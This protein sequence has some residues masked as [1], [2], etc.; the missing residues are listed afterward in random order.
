M[1]AEPLTGA[2][3]GVRAFKLGAS[4]C[5][6]GWYARAPGECYVPHPVCDLL[7]PEVVGLPGPISTLCVST[8]LYDETHDDAV[9]V[10]FKD[11][12]AWADIE[13]PMLAFSDHWG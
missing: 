10:M 3:H 9:R 8:I 13:C 1:E 2:N 7:P 12:T 4:D 6:C 5:L 11:F